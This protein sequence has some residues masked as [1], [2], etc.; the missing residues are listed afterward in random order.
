MFEQQDELQERRLQHQL[1]IQS[2]Q[3]E[4]VFNRHQVDAHVAGGTVKPRLISFNLQTQLATGLERLKVLTDDLMHT[5]GVPVSLSR[6]DGQ[7]RLD[8]SQPTVPPVS[9]LDLM[10]L[11]SDL[12]PVTAVLGLAEDGRPVLLDFAEQDMTHILVSGISGA[13]KTAL[14]RSLVMSLA[15]LNR[16]SRVQFVVF[17]GNSKDADAET[18]LHSLNY[19]PHMLAN[20]MC[21]QND[22]RDTLAFLTEE[23]SYRLEYE[24]VAPTIVVVIDQVDTLLE[25]GDTLIRD[26][27][28]TLVQRGSEV[29]VHL[30]MSSQRPQTA[31]LDNLFK[32]N[33]SVQLVGRLADSEQAQTV[34]GLRSSQAEFLLGQGDFLAIAGQYMTHFQAAY[35]GDYDLHLTLQELYRKRPPTLLAQSVDE[36][37]SISLSNLDIENTSDELPQHFLYKGDEVTLTYE[38]MFPSS[39]VIE[40]EAYSADDDFEDAEEEIYVPQPVIRLFHDDSTQDME[41]A[42]EMEDDDL[43]TAVPPS[44]ALSGAEVDAT[45]VATIYGALANTWPRPKYVVSQKT[46][47]EAFSTHKSQLPSQVRADE[48]AEDIMEVAQTVEEDEAEFIADSDKTDNKGD[49][50][51]ESGYVKF[52]DDWLPFDDD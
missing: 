30:V 5:L 6:E 7:L 47:V 38:D 45:E 23:I 20:V 46:D 32:A 9:L 17:D 27:I 41:L 37:Q 28:V 44:H 49:D 51:P 4:H 22:I 12:S 33:I 11:L 34:T 8:V 1:E 35:I 26:A 40:T 14:L 2:M 3:I 36:L 29:G 48:I 50:E 21:H 39:T 52:E 31:V 10:A 43:D 15:L 16:Q 13:G 18:D 19:L 42:E 24:V 25:T